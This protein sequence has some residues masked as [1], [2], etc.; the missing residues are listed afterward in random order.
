MLAVHLQKR[1]DVDEVITSRT[2]VVCTHADRL[3]SSL[4]GLEGLTHH[5]SCAQVCGRPPES[6]SFGGVRS[7][8]HP[9]PLLTGRRASPHRRPVVGSFVVAAA[10]A[11]TDRP[12]FRYSSQARRARPSVP[13]G[14][15]GWPRVQHLRRRT[16]NRVSASR[17]GGAQIPSIAYRSAKRSSSAVSAIVKALW[18]DEWLLAASAQQLQAGFNKLCCPWKDSSLRVEVVVG[19]KSKE[20]KK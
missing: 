18:S 15:G 8:C 7:S 13:L 11:Q 17:S 9:S 12:G 14:Q 3:L 10:A 19:G 20:V 4:V 5:L 6:R 1:Y 16:S 2:I